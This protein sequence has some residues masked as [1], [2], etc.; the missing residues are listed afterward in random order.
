MHE[1]LPL[2]HKRMGGISGALGCRF[3]PPAKAQVQLGSYPWP[4]DATSHETDR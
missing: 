2:Q 1:E 3:D 4:W